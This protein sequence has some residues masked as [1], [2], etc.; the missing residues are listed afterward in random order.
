VSMRQ[1]TTCSALC[2]EWA[3]LLTQIKYETTQWFPAKYFYIFSITLK[4]DLQF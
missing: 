4:N 3:D 2:Q 1:T